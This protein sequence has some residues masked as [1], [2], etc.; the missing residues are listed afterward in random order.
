[1]NI[2]ILAI[3]K[4][5]DPK[6]LAAVEEYIKRLSHY[7][8]L[9]WKL[10]EAKVTSSMI[11]DQIKDAESDVLIKHLPSSSAVVLLDETGENLSSPQLAK[12]LQGYKN[13]ST[14]NLVFVIGGSYGVSEKVK[15]RSDFVWSLSNLVF[16]HQ[17][18]RLILIEQLYRAHTI[19]AGEKYHH[20]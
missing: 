9:N 12:K 20:S 2:T 17:L 4:K 16:P 11:P 14:K 1:M 18:V 19:L 8:K 6:M 15:D 7:T 13:S 10:V 5:N 3:G